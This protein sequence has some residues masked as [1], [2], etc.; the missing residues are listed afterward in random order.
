[1]LRQTVDA[2]SLLIHPNMC[3]GS[4]DRLVLDVLVIT[5]EDVFDLLLRDGPKLT[6][7]AR[8]R[9]LVL[10]VSVAL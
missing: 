4:L 2:V 5:E 7:V 1:M 3:A 10:R 6:G 9:R 8:S